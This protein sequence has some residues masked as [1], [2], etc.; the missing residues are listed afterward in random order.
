M[1]KITDVNAVDD[2]FA[3][4][5]EAGIPILAPNFESFTEL[6]AEI[7]AA[8]TIADRFGIE[9]VPIMPSVTLAYP[10]RGNVAGRGGAY[11]DI[12]TTLTERYSQAELDGFIRLGYHVANHDMDCFDG[13]SFF[14]NVCAVFAVD[15]GQPE[16]DKVLLEDRE[17]LEHVGL[18]MY[19]VTA[20]LKGNAELKADRERAVTVI[21]EAVASYRERF[22]DLVRIESA[23]DILPEAPAEGSLPDADETLSRP[24]E[25]ERFLQISGADFFA[26]S[27]GTEHRA[28]NPEGPDKLYREDV[29]KNLHERVVAMP[30]YDSV[31][32]TIFSL[33]GS[34]CLDPS[35]ESNADLHEK[36]HGMAIFRYYTGLSTKQG[37][38]MKQWVDDADRRV[39]ADP[40]DGL[41]V[42]AASGRDSYIVEQLQ[43]ELTQ[44]MVNLGYEKL[45]K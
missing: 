23:C 3:E 37:Q 42:N 43:P 18:V 2:L 36:L 15:H 28:R 22:D 35:S 17:V 33:H 9:R 27:I 38:A 10:D 14:P 30:Q 41:H 20:L 13:T 40:K 25:M 6:L 32:G 5:R 21:G 16:T 12:G 44:V 34:S 8:Q 7:Q 19:D 31:G 29:A 24:D 26:P 11:Q 45:A 4:A 1:K 39:A